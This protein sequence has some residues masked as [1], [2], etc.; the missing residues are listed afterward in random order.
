MFCFSIGRLVGRARKVRGRRRRRSVEAGVGTAA[1]PV[2][3]PKQMGRDAA[4]AARQ[5]GESSGGGDDLTE[6]APG[7]GRIG[8]GPAPG[9]TSGAASPDDGQS[10]GSSLQHAH[11]LWGL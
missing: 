6:P 1:Q 11:W 5:S 7:H 9:L 10:E 3:H 8:P 4:E 2:R